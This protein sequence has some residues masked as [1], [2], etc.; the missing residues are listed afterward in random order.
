MHLFNIELKMNVPNALSLFRIALLPLFAYLYLNGGQNQTYSH[1]AFGVFIL[2]GISDS[3][4]GIIARKFNQIT[5]LGKILDPLADKLTQV[6][7]AVCLALRYRIVVY[8]LAICLVKEICQTIGSVIL[9]RRGIKIQGARWFGKIST[10]TFYG[11][12]ILIV[13][14]P[15][16]PQWLLTTLV[17]IVALLMV[18]AFVNYATMFFSIKKG[19]DQAGKDGGEGAA[20]AAAKTDD[21]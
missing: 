18:F 15:E 12:M 7:V 17:V 9:L 21:A 1:L 14:W 6:T 5:D 13:G 2:S 19:T 11:V 10:F 4:D 16:M 8:L 20:G 3:L